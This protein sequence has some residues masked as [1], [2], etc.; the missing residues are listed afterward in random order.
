MGVIKVGEGLL[1]SAA[2]SQTSRSKAGRARGSNFRRYH[3]VRCCGLAFSTAARRESRGLAARRGCGSTFR[4]PGES[5]RG[6]LGDCSGRRPWPQ[7]PPPV[8]QLALAAPA[9]WDFSQNPS[10]A[11][12]CWRQRRAQKTR[13]ANSPIKTGFRPDPCFLRGDNSWRPKR[14]GFGDRFYF[15]KRGFRCERSDTNSGYRRT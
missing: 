12:L 13:H 8:P 7:C 10:H 5:G 9:A 14:I 4:E 15:H 3:T 2:V 6:R 1:W 11:F